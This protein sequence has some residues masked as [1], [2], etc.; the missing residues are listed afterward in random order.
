[1]SSI[2]VYLTFENDEA[3]SR[4]L[5]CIR[6]LADAIILFDQREGETEL[7]ALRTR[8]LLGRLVGKEIDDEGFQLLFTCVEEE[9]P[10]LEVCMRLGEYF[11]KRHAW[12]QTIFWFENALRIDG[13]ESSFVCLRLGTSYGE[14]GQWE[15]AATYMKL[16]EIF[17]NGGLERLGQSDRDLDD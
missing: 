17:G 15:A 7:R 2:G 13:G 5:A 14:I 9:T 11:Y 4:C 10:S 1:M 3:L 12:K 16:A 6:P 8:Q